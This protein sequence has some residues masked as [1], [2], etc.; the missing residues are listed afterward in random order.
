MVVQSCCF[1]PESSPRDLQSGHGFRACSFEHEGKNVDFHNVGGQ[2]SK[3]EKLNEIDQ[4]LVPG[5]PNNTKK[6]RKADADIF[7]NFGVKQH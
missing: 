6:N 3:N 5:A 7:A 2:K 1:F 4:M